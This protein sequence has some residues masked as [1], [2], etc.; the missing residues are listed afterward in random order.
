M[1]RGEESSEKRVEHNVD[2]VVTHA[3]EQVATNSAGD[4]F[5]DAV[6]DPAPKKRQATPRESD[7]PTIPFIIV[8]PPSTT[9]AAPAIDT[10]PVKVA[11][12]TPLAGKTYLKPNVLYPPTASIERADVCL[13]YPKRVASRSVKTTA[14]ADSLAC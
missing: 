2:G 7:D 8:S 6:L 4:V 11:A 12:T 9:E 14:C 3:S 13:G 1:D 10:E 5:T